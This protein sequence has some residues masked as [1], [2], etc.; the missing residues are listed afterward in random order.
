MK[1]KILYWLLGVLILL[2]ATNPSLSDF[3]DNDH[4]ACYK[5][6]NYLIFSV[7]VENI[8]DENGWASNRQ[9]T[10]LGIFKN[11]FLVDGDGPYKPTVR[12]FR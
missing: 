8:N 9:N 3:K 11:F 7:F 2:L 1:K 12:E 10:Y 6:A 4:T 5:Q